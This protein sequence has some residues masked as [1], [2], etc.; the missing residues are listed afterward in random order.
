MSNESIQW[1]RFR[2]ETGEVY[3]CPVSAGQHRADHQSGLDDC[4]ESSTIGRYA[5]NINRIEPDVVKGM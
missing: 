1:G 4:V 2:D 3:Y 5:G